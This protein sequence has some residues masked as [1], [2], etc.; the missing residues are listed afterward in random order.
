MSANS[1]AEAFFGALSAHSDLA[2]ELLASL[3]AL[4]EYEVRYASR[5]YGALFAVTK[6]TVFCGAAGMSNTYWRLRPAD[7]EVALA[8][9]ACR[10]P[11][12]C[13]ESAA[14]GRQTGATTAQST[15]AVRV[16]MRRFPISIP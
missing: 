6:S 11:A 5:E 15:T 16:F 10:A 1:E 2:D 13:I 14:T 4:G 12:A 8:T 9:G 7:H 3:K